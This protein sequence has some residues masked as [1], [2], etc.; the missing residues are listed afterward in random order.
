M[1]VW[2]VRCGGEVWCVRCGGEV[3]CVRCGVEHEMSIQDGMW[4][5]G[6]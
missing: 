6:G 1:G 5:E 3:W 4:S 2:G